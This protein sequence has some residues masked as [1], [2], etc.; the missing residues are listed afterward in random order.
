MRYC[1]STKGLPPEEYFKVF[2]EESRTLLGED[3]R[4][5][6]AAIASGSPRRLWFLLDEWVHAGRLRG[7]RMLNS[8]HDFWLQYL[9]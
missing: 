3:Q 1:N 2:R 8:L 9:Q 7:E 6:E 4:E 5:L